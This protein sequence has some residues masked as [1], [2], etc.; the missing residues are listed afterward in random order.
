MEIKEYI[1]FKYDEIEHLYNAVG[2]SAY[3][4]YMYSLEQGYKK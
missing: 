4:D 3:T 2:W 1:D